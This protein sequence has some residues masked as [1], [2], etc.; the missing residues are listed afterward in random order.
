MISLCHHQRHQRTPVHLLPLQNIVLA[1][2]A[3]A[4][5][6]GPD[7]D[8]STTQARLLVLNKAEAT[9]SLFDPATRREVGL[10]DVGNGPHEVAV[11]PDGRTA[12]VSNYG[13]RDPGS[14]LTLIDIVG[15]E[16]LGNMM[17]VGEEGAGNEQK[18][19]T[20][21]R[22]HGL[23]FLPDG[24]HVVVTSESTRRLLVVDI[25][26]REVIRTLPTKQPSL[27]LLALSVDG[28]TAFG[29]SPDGGT[30]NVLDLSADGS[31][32]AAI[33]ATGAGAEGLAI[34]PDGGEVWVCNRATDS[35]SIVDSAARTII[36]ELHTTASPMRVAFT[37]DGAHALV[38]CAEAGQLLVF[39]TGTRRLSQT[40]ELSGD[41]SEQSSMPVGICVQPDGRFAWVACTRGEFLAV[42]DLQNFEFVDRV[43]A[44]RGPDGMAFAQP[45]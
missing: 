3:A 43:K 34:S 35:V 24:R 33:I 2:A 9:V 32:A 42:I 30:L 14:T 36:A 41:N 15:A 4:Q 31:S 26:R 5:A 17:L 28:R 37:P 44:R 39:E 13:N 45:R 38:S 20:Y 21:L 27:H 29:T 6:P 22:P 25:D 18:L 12:V 16:S 10:V 11:S 8:P 1:C 23:T 7:P 40:V 19:R